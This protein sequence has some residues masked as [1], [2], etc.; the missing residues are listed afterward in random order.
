MRQSTCHSC[1]GCGTRRTHQSRST[2]HGARLLHL[3]DGASPQSG[4]APG[5]PADYLRALAE[6]PLD[7][8]L[9]LRDR[10]NRFRAACASLADVT[11]ARLGAR[12]AFK[13]ERVLPI[14]AAAL[15]LVEGVLGRSDPAA[16]PIEATPLE[17]APAG[18]A[19][20]A[21]GGLATTTAVVA[22]LAG[23]IAYFERSEPSNPALLLLKQAQRLIG[24]NFLEIMRIL[25][26][27]HFEQAVFGIGRAH[28]LDLPMP[29]LTEPFAGAP[30][31]QETQPAEPA[32]VRDRSGALALLQ[33]IESF[34]A[35]AE[36]SS[37]I[38]SLC[39]RSRK[40]CSVDFLT[41]LKQILPED[42]LKSSS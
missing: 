32:P 36:P 6:S 15:E 7:D 27:D 40:F 39:E 24:R 16:S 9:A 26:P 1:G 33:Q 4:E 25:A 14:V 12:F 11:T 28:Q 30:P 19:P 29:R 5:D 2:R 17:P 37:P 22:A 42:T 8:L 10:L 23:V 20:A 21:T 38:P 34:Y 18:A 41:I 13:S 3:A 31:D 35:S